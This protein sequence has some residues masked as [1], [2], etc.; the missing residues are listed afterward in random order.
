MIK[1]KIYHIPNYVYPCGSVGK[2]GL[3]EQ[4]VEQRMKGNHKKS[5]KPFDFWEILE[6][7]DDKYTASMRELELQREYG[8]LVD[9][10]PYHKL[11][12]KEKV[13]SKGGKTQL[14]E[15]K[16]KGL[17]KATSEDKSKGGK[18]GGKIRSEQITFQELSYAGKHN[19]TL[20]DYEVR[21]LRQQYER[22]V[23]M[24]DNKITIKRLRQVIPLAYGAMWNL[25]NYKS[26]TDII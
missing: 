26:Y 4:E 12:N 19:R 24:N 2:V 3:T 7:H 16:M 10:I 13:Q 21:W 6:V 25:L 15:D 22:G 9:T 20:E 11:V 17:N 14:L 5:L 23:D 18:I 1:Y 8:Y